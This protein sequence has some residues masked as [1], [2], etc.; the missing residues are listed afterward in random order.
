MMKGFF[1]GLV[2]AR[3]MVLESERSAGKTLGNARRARLGQS[4][5]GISKEQ[6]SL[7]STTEES[8]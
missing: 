6:I 3:T 1:N 7:M 8:Q 4:I 2:T 5:K